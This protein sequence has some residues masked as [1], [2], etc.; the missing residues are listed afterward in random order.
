MPQI[1]SFHHS[2]CLWYLRDEFPKFHVYATRAN[3][4]KRVYYKPNLLSENSVSKCLP[5]R[6]VKAKRRG[7]G[8]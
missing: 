7:H 8:E 2:A 1:A 5:G 3:V 6:I 4:R